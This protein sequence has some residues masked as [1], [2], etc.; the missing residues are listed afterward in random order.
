M[1]SLCCAMMACSSYTSLQPD[2]VGEGGPKLVGANHTHGIPYYLPK[3]VLKIVMNKKD[4]VISFS[5]H[6]EKIADREW[7]FTIKSGSYLFHDIDQEIEVQ[8]GLLTSLNATDTGQLDEIA[9]A[10][11]GA[12]LSPPIALDSLE[13]IPLPL[14]HDGDRNEDSQEPRRVKKPEPRITKKEYDAIIK[15]IPDG[16]HELF[17]ELD[18]GEADVPGTFGKLRIQVSLG[19]GYGFASYSSKTHLDGQGDDGIDSQHPTNHSH[20]KDC[21]PGFFSRAVVP[22]K[23]HISI[24]PAKK[25][26]AGS[27]KN[28]NDKKDLTKDLI[29]NLNDYKVAL[30]GFYSDIEKLYN[31]PLDPGVVETDVS[32]LQDKIDEATKQIAQSQLLILKDIPE[33][34][35]KSTETLKRAEDIAVAD[36]FLENIKVILENPKVGVERRLMDSVNEVGTLNILSEEIIEL[37]KNNENADGKVVASILGY[38]QKQKDQAQKNIQDL[39]KQSLDLNQVTYSTQLQINTWKKEG[40]KTTPEVEYVGNEKGELMSKDFLVHVIDESQIYHHPVERGLVG[41]FVQ[42]YSFDKG[43]V[44]KKKVTKPSQVLAVLKIPTNVAKEIVSVPA[45]LFASIATSRGSQ[46]TILE[47]EKKILDNATALLNAQNA[48]TADTTDLDAFEKEKERLSRQL[49]LLTIQSQ[50]DNILNPDSTDD[51]E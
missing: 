39:T 32:L 51:E 40:K 45:E 27:G 30:K 47:N 42:N 2:S 19:Q 46:A 13:D 14:E 35:K 6:P 34:L 12:V 4:G 18:G 44:T 5:I 20:R 23:I 3:T 41:Q 43:V 10:V 48:L 38:F 24:F 15:G 7:P 8:N 36:D 29:K 22:E 49:E 25:N 33:E 37:F 50:I 26:S 31:K 28:S 16:D 17:F 9:K 21:H 11:V 1:L